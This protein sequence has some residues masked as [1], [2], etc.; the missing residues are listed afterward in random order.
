MKRFG[1][2]FAV[3][4][5]LGARAGRERYE[6]IAERSRK[7]AEIPAVRD[8]LDRAPDVLKSSGARLMSTV[9]ERAGMGDDEDADAGARRDEDEFDGGADDGDEGGGARARRPAPSSR[10]RPAGG[11]QS[12]PQRSGR[13]SR[14]SSLAGIASAARERGKIA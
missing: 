14:T 1:L 6:E 13:K 4:Y 9:K 5:V 8:V 3:G 10:R 11:S 12:G 2:G 7:L